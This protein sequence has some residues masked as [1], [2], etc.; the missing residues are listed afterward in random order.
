MPSL[1][2]PSLLAHVALRRGL[3]RRV[4]LSSDSRELRGLPPLAHR[5]FGSASFVEGEPCS[6]R[7]G[8]R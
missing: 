8:L 1:Y 3:P 7:R 2:L 4:V 5:P 6:K